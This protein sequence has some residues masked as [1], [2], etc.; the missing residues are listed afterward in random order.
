MSVR[1][2][3]IF[4]LYLRFCSPLICILFVIISLAK[5][6]LLLNLSVCNVN[7]YSMRPARVITAL[8][9]PILRKADAKLLKQQLLANFW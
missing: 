3:H 8:L 2:L 6:I 4:I 7:D 1:V 9:S 5:L